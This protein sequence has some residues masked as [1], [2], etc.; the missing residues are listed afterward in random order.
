MSIEE[1]NL[2]NCAAVIV[3]LRTSEA[4]GAKWFAPA[5]NRVAT[6]LFAALIDA[7]LKLDGYSVGEVGRAGWW[8]ASLFVAPVQPQHL[9]AAK[10]VVS[11]IVEK[12]VI[13][14]RAWVATMGPEGS[15]PS[16]EWTLEKLMEF[17]ECFGVDVEAGVEMRK[18]SDGIKEIFKRISNL[19]R[20]VRE[21]RDAGEDWKR[22]ED[23]Q[24]DD[25]GGDEAK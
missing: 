23:E 18:T 6:E 1:M 20:E 22:P 11:K 7:A 16:P 15:A 19:E 24:G 10:A 4:W 21:Q 13:S 8:N 25:A 17:A 14:E 2:K 9:D 12:I 5:K 3:A